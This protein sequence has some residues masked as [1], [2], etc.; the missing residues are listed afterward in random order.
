MYHLQGNGA[1]QILPVVH[2]FQGITPPGFITANSPSEPGSCVYPHKCRGIICKA[3]LIPA[4]G[5]GP[6]ID[7]T[8]LLPPLVHQAACV[9]TPTDDPKALAA[10]FAFF[11]SLLLD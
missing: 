10:S 3:A 2:S 1:P 6:N 5:M 4:L 9:V 7:K 8:N 11:F